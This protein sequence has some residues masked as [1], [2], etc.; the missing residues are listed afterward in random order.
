MPARLEETPLV[1]N[2]CKHEWMEPLI[3][4]VP[5]DVWVAHVRSLRCPGCGAG[6]DHL[7]M[8]GWGV[9]VPELKADR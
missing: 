2:A 3:Y 9:P 5:I 1:C 6:P 4:N 7:A 8:R